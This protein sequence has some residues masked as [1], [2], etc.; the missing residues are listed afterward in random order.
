VT[1]LINAA[2]AVVPRAD[3]AE[4]RVGD[5]CLGAL[6]RILPVDAAHAEVFDFEEF[7]DAVF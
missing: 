3:K 7:L 4:A 6:F 1:V 5:D 2:N